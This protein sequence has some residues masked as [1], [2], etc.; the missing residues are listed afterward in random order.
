MLN[1]NRY[2]RVVTPIFHSDCAEFLRR[3]IAKAIASGDDATTRRMF[4][5]LDLALNGDQANPSSLQAW[6]SRGHRR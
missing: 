2:L 5:W 3:R 1:Q 4:H 6:R